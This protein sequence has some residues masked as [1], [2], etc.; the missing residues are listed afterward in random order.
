MVI[1]SHE[2]NFIYQI[3]N[4][5]LFMDGGVVLESGTPEEVFVHKGRA[6]QAVLIESSYF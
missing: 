5:V 1:V 2:M 6:N 3:C 4:K